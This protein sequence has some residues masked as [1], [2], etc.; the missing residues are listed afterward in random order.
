V[1]RR[2]LLALL[3][4]FTLASCGNQDPPP[5]PSQG[6]PSDAVQISGGERL[7]WSQQ[8]ANPAELGTFQYAI[9]VDGVRSDLAGV[10]CGNTEGAAGFDCSAPLPRL[11]V[12]SH[13]IEL[14]SFVVD[15]STTLESVRS[16][17]L[18]VTMSGLASAVTA[19]TSS[20]VLTAE[21][22]SLRLGRV[23]EGLNLPSDLAF[24]PDGAIFV[25]ERGGTV[26]VVRDGTRV[27]RPALDLSSDVELPEGGLL[28]IALDPKF[29][30]SGIAYTL[31]AS[32]MSPTD[33]D[34]LAFTLARFRVVR[35]IF[36]E[37][38][39]LLHRIPASHKGASGALRVGPDG[40]LYLA[41]DTAADGRRAGSLASYNGKVLRLNTDATTPDDQAGLTPIYSLDHPLPRA[42][43]WQPSSGA[44]WI[45]DES[46]TAVGRLSAVAAENSRQKRA[47]V[48][49]R[50]T[51]PADI[52]P[53]SAAFY[54]GSLMSVFRDNLF[55]AAET[56]RH[57][58]R[59]QFDPL[60]SERIVSVERLLQDQIGAVR[61]VAAGPDGALYVGSDTALYRLAP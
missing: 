17:P 25:A 13:T 9:Y 34:G 21:H 44:L 60:N 50:Y 53:S 37:R 24:G 56:G 42:L 15:G 26:R 14:A 43:D 29:E 28:A 51:L 30:E 45:V 6:Q 55:I 33:G 2:F 3:A 11:S 18:R 39:I 48:R 59:L 32:R 46:E 4:C 40:K 5:T 20:A 61:V 35:D 27:P 22:V 54:R 1:L 12:G 8:A 57:L 41:L 58:I 31:H 47:V 10:T 52:G 36:G 38:A 16:S 23:A 49:V 19:P 7:G